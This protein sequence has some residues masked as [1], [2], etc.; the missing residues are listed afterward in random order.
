VH[1]ICADVTRADLPERA[2]AFWHDR[3]TFHFL[4]DPLARRLYVEVAR[5][6]VRPGGHVVVAT[7]GPRGPGKCSGLDVLRFSPEALR[8]EFGDEF[9]RVSDATEIHT[10]PW[11]AEQEFVYCYC[12]LPE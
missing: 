4:T 7:F 5:R 3:A 11:G 1:W 10:T 9:A 2:F 8:A 6:S 12:R